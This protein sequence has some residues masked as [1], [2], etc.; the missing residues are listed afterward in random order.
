MNFEG[1]SDH[2][3]FFHENNRTH[4]ECH[5]LT[6]GFNPIVYMSL[7]LLM[8]KRAFTL[9]SRALGCRE[10][11]QHEVDSSPGVSTRATFIY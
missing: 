2:T 7:V 10:T 8:R 9:L 4:T 6:K 3:Y 11:L 5:C 1:Q